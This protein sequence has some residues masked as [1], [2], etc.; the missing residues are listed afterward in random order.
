MFLPA[1]AIAAKMSVETGTEYYAQPARRRG[2]TKPSCPNEAKSP[3]RS[4]G[5]RTKPSRP[6]E[7]KS[8]RTEPSRSERSQV[9][10]NEAKSPERGQVA[11]TKPTRKRQSPPGV[12]T[13]RRQSP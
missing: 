7:A 11:R 9:G 2:R 3:E 5:A 10:P 13:A 12:T 4:Q 1:A 8:V 6:N